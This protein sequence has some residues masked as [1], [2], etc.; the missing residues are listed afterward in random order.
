MSDIRSQLTEVLT[1]LDSNTG[2]LNELYISRAIQQLKNP[3]L[4][5]EGPVEWTAESIAFDFEEPPIGKDN[6]WGT[7][8]GPMMSWKE[9]DGTPQYYP[10]LGQITP[11]VITYWQH[12]AQKPI[13]PVLKARYAGLVWDFSKRQVGLTA[14]IEMAHTQ[15]DSIVQ[16]ARERLQESSVSII[17]KLTRALDLATRLSD[18]ARTIIVAD[19]M[20]EYEDHVAQDDMIGLWGFSFDALIDNKGVPLSSDTYLK[21][22]SDLES[23]L[24]RVSGSA[25]ECKINPWAAEAAATRLARH[26]RRHNKAHEVRR[27]L[28]KYRDAFLQ[29]GKSEDAILASAW[30]QQVHAVLRDFGLANESDQLLKDIRELGPKASKQLISVSA[31][32]EITHEEMQQYVAEMLE[33]DM[34]SVLQR[35]AIR[36]I[37]SRTRAEQ[38][39]KTQKD[40]HPLL[41]I[42]HKTIVDHL[43]RPVAAI[44]PLEDDLD[45]NVIH[46]IAQ[47][48]G[49]TAIFVRRAM[50]AAILKFSLD[51]LTLSEHLYAAPLFRDE[52]RQVIERG[53]QAYIAN[54]TIVAIHVLIPQI[55]DAIRTLVEHCGGTVLKVARNGCYNVKSFDDVLRDRCVREAL[56]DDISLY[57]RALFTDPRGLNVRNNVM[58]AITPQWGFSPIIADRVMHAL[59]VLAQVRE[60]APTDEGATTS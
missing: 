23:R 27:V 1:S 38:E 15:I 21:L 20:M 12:R 46:Y 26:Y 22:T 48:I 50:E 18:T 3:G 25:S 45:G 54:D 53:V 31:E 60:V 36:Y 6:A 5:Q 4:S 41:H 47:N 13:H 39:L 24:D 34:T 56:G 37:P 42:F 29:K 8:F 2:P 59:L 17:T 11:D 44:G 19:A 9:Q 10:R 32:M 55:E 35:I 28:L 16:I 52:K 30:L 49:Y 51:S 40:E 33:G 7:Y 57:F 14:P 43:G 58:H